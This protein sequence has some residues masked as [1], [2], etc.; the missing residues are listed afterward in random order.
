LLG[1]IAIRSCQSIR[2]ELSLSV[3]AAWNI[4]SNRGD[5]VFYP[6][7][8]AH[9]SRGDRRRCFA[10]LSRS[11]ATRGSLGLQ[12]DLAGR[13]SQHA[14]HRQRSHVCR[15]R[16]RRWRHQDHPCRRRWHHAAESFASSHRRTIRDARFA[17]P[18]PYRSRTGPRSW[19]RSAHCSRSSAQHRTTFLKTLRN[20][21]PILSRMHRING[22]TPFPVRAFASL[23][24]YSDRVSSVRNLQP[25]SVCP[26]HSH[27]ISRPRT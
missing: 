15:H 7:S 22:F 16:P 18:R 12:T 1:S 2:N 3:T 25:N 23:Y 13:T 27:R 24:G 9:S 21:N 10:Q 14:R 17:L 4:A 8:L 6:R 19:D 5:S 11:R 26:L 20:C